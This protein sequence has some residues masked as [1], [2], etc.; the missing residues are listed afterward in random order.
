MQI[1]NGLGSWA[2]LGA[3]TKGQKKTRRS[4]KKRCLAAQLQATEPLVRLPPPDYLKLNGAR[5]ST[6]KPPPHD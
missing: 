4:K 6:S 1:Q 5:L 2:K 3:R